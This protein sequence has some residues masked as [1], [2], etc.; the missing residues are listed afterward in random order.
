VLEVSGERF[1]CFSRR[2]RRVS[3]RILS[4]IVSGVNLGQTSPAGD[5]CCFVHCALA[6]MHTGTRRQSLIGVG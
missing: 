2:N 4:A 1:S 6:D 3:S 5:G